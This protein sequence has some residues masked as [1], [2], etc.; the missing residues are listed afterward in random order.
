MT[1][2]VPGTCSQRKR[3][4][5]FSSTIFI[6]LH[7]RLCLKKSLKVRVTTRIGKIV[8]SG[9]ALALTLHLNAKAILAG[10]ATIGLNVTG[11]QEQDPPPPPPERRS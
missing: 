5:C 8:I 10:Y 2:S 1:L 3:R 6:F 7:D 11:R 4:G 9:C